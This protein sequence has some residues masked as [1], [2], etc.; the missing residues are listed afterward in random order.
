MPRTDA[1]DL[2][3]VNHN[4]AELIVRFLTTLFDEG[5]DDQRIKVYI[6]DNGSTDGSREMLNDISSQF[7]I[8]KIDFNDNI[9]YARACNKLASYGSSDIIGLLNAD[10]WLTS[11]D[12]DKLLWTFDKHPE[13]HII[14]PKQ[15]DEAGRITH[16][17]IFGTHTA[18]KHRGWR[19]HDPDN[20]KYRDFTRAITVSGAAYFVRRDAWNEIANC[21]IRQKE[22]IVR[23]YADDGG[24]GGFLPTPHYFEETMCS[25]EAY[26][27][28][29]GV[30][31]DGF[32]SI[33][34]TWHASSKIGGEADQLFRTSQKIF[35]TACDN[36]NIPHD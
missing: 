15:R 33:G 32:T 24:H 29:F 31:Y 14:G 17:G 7:K 18:P 12:V 28:G 2:C 3:V 34:H 6:A 20:T 8:T 23:K 25:Y 21:P 13:A 36:H 19:E 11:N 4:T 22:P 10:V 9:G 5:F 30:Y 26:A 1:I 35:R 16:A 27:H